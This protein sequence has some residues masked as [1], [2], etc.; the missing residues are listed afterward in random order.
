MVNIMKRTLFLTIGVFAVL[1]L[2]FGVVL[3]EDNASSDDSSV[4]KAKD[5]AYENKKDLG[6]GFG[7]FKLHTAAFLLMNYDTNVSNVS[8]NEAADL[9]LI[10]NGGL[11]LNYPS[12]MAAMSF[13]GDI[14]YRRYF[15]IDKSDTTEL[16]NVFGKARLAL[17]FL[18]ASVFSFGVSDTFARTATPEGVVIFDVKTRINNRAKG[19]VLLQPNG[20]DGTLKIW[21]NYV[22]NYQRYDA[23]SMVNFNYVKH[24]GELVAEY[25]FLP[26]TSVYLSGSFD[27]IKYNDFVKYDLD[28]V[29]K[30]A[31]YEENTNPM[32]LKAADAMPFDVRVG[33]YGLITPYLSTNVYIG[34][35]NTLSENLDSFNS[36]IVKAEATVLPLDSTRIMLGFT[37]SSMPLNTYGYVASNKIYLDLQQW[38]MN[39]KIRLGLVGSFDY[40]TFG[41]PDE[42][43]VKQKFTGFS[44]TFT[45]LESGRADKL[46]S[47]DVYVNYD[48]LP[49]MSVSLDYTVDFKASG[50]DNLHILNFATNKYTAIDYGFVKHQVMFKY[51]ISY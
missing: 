22:N 34:Y 43:A 15:G 7:G 30:T 24:T 38:V 47:A 31:K 3:A 1:L 19:Y 45:G 9:S 17:A 4:S 6:F 27:Y 25:F 35:A 5:S 13:G 37:R 14:G 21:L 39:D 50:A 40:Q 36:V 8:A 18:R 32:V 42:E 20:K 29:K 28:A 51:Q 49:W 41:D 12:D 48:I 23:D 10:V 16:S 33:V 2:S 11:R 44:T 46:I 26:K